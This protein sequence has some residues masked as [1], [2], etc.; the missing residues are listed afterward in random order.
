LRT[1]FTYDIV[2]KSNDVNNKKTI[3]YSMYMLTHF[4]VI[5]SMK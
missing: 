2:T 4:V 1:N 3:D 5:L